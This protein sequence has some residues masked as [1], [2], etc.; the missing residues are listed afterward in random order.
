MLPL[1]LICSKAWDKLAPVKLSVS[2]ILSFF[3]SLIST[4]ISERAVAIVS[5]IKA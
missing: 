4:A 5:E 3:E 2:A 1:L